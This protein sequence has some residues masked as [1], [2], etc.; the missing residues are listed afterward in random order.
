MVSANGG[1][2]L[3]CCRF[4]CEDGVVTRNGWFILD[5]EVELCYL[6]CST[7]SSAFFQWCVLHAVLLYC[8]LL[9]QCGE[10]GV[11]TRNGWFI[12]D[13][14]VELCYLRCITLASAF[15]SMVCVLHA[16]LLYCCLLV[17]CGEDGVVTRNGWFI[18]DYEVESSC[19]HTSPFP[20]H[21]P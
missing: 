15:F 6:R 9:V 10:D 7:L 16:V 20:H 14:E 21:A 8:C 17:Q 2:V 11:V 5:Y 1:S 19:L 3:F 13:Y 18:L 12:L 4:Q